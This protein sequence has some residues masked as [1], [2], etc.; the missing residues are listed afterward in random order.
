MNLCQ[1]VEL[2]G[3]KKCSQGTGLEAPK[4]WQLNGKALASG[5][6]GPRFDSRSR[7]EKIRCPNM[8]SLVSF[9]GMMLD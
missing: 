9:A 4:A 6:R 3:R 8:L 5:A 1:L 7:R 2:G